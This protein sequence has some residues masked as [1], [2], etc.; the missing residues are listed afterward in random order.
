VEKVPGLK[1]TLRFGVAIGG[2]VTR[3]PPRRFQ[4]KSQLTI[5]SYNNKKK[6]EENMKVGRNSWWIQ[7]GGGRERGRDTN[8]DPMRRAGNSPQS[9]KAHKRL[10][11]VIGKKG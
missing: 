4:L 8:V 9:Q 10:Q 2:R 1:S 11:S 6:R 3:K 5:L 7:V